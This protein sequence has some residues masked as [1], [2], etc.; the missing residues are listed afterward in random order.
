MTFT[1][2]LFLIKLLPEAISSLCTLYAANCFL[3]R[4][5]KNRDVI[6]DMGHNFVTVS[7]LMPQVSTVTELSRQPDT[8]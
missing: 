8:Q 1:F 7:L 3:D 6:I 2:Y 5:L 4:T